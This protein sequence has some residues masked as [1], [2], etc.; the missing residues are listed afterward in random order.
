MIGTATAAGITWALWKVATVDT[1]TLLKATA[2]TF[3]G[4]RPILL[5]GMRYMGMEC[6]S[7]RDRRIRSLKRKQRVRKQIRNSGMQNCIPL[8]LTD[9]NESMHIMSTK[10]GEEP[11]DV[12]EY[13]RL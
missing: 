13:L 11:F 1:F 8:T 10:P 7:I 5:D 3:A 2:V 12:N 6:L 9:T 4:E